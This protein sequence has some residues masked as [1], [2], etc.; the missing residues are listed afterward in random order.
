[1][2]TQDGQISLGL[3][4][5]ELDAIFPPMPK[6]CWFKTRSVLFRCTNRS[7]CSTIYTGTPI[8]LITIMPC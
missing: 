2:T 7:S 3:Q 4:L 6:S 1:M 8:N 5:D